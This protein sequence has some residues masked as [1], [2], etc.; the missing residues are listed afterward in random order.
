MKKISISIMLSI[1]FLQSTNYLKAPVGTGEQPNGQPVIEAP[2]APIAP[3]IE[4]GYDPSAFVVTDVPNV[5]PRVM[6]GPKAESLLFKAIHEHN[7]SEVRRI[8]ERNPSAVL[9]RE[10]G[11][12]T[13]L[14]EAIILGDTDIINMLL[15][16]AKISD[17]INTKDNSGKTAL[18][19]VAGHILDSQNYKAR[20]KTKAEASYDERSISQDENL[21]AALLNAGANPDVCNAEEQKIINSVRFKSSSEEKESASRRSRKQSK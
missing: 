16:D 21:I 2:S 15:K 17:F 10:I 11:G 19:T 6:G 4:T 18:C 8:I 9:E 12:R 13:V 5:V 14:Q 3:R 20:A 7:A 1:I